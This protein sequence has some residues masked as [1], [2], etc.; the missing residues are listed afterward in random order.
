MAVNLVN[1]KEKIIFGE[2]S[3]V[4]AKYGMSLPGGRAL[5]TTGFADTVI[6]AGHVIIK[7]AEGVYK[8]MPVSNGNYAELPG[9]H[10]YVGVLY[11]SILTAK[12]SASILIDGVVNEAALPYSIATIKTA[13]TAA[14]PHIIFVKDEPTDVKS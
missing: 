7:S 5:D 4:I 14:V 13:F 6:K 1:K 9:S 11:R 2:D 10:T 12:P 3:I 8:P